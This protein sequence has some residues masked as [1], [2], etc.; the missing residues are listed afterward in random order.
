MRFNRQRAAKRKKA[1]LLKDAQH[2]MQ[3]GNL[4]GVVSKLQYIREKGDPAT[5]EKLIEFIMSFVRHG[6]QQSKVHQVCFIHYCFMMLSSVINVLH[7]C[8]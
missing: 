2:A 7:V 5:S 6:E 1:R 8:M 4:R 3:L